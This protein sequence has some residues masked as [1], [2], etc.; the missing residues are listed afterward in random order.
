LINR[1]PTG[2]QQFI[3]MKTSLT[4]LLLASAATSTLAFVPLH[5]TTK[6]TMALF[7]RVDSSDLVKEALEISKKFGA[8]SPEARLAWET[9][10]EVEAS[11]N[12]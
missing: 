11:D 9:V 8:S 6:S 7:D 1:H 2:N 4:I 12:R 5:T 3:I 10:E